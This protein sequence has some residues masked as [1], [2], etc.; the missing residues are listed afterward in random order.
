MAHDDR[1]LHVRLE[2]P[3]TRLTLDRPA[4]LN[5]LDDG[6]RL[7]LR[8]VLTELEDR[9][10]IRV[11]LLD[12]AGRAFSA[13]ADLRATAYPPI[14]GDWST[15]RHRAGTWQRLLD[16][17]ERVPQATVA[18]LHGHVVGG[19]A[20]LA[21]AFDIRVASADTRLRIPELAIGIPLTWAG[22]PRLIRE[23]GLPLT[24]DWVMSGRV[25]L[26]EELSRSGFAQR[27]AAPEDLDDAVEA[28]IGELLAMPPAALAMTRSM[29]AA[30][31]RTT[32]GM[33]AA[34]GDADHQQWAFT[35]H[36][37]HDAVRAYV[38]GLRG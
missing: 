35:E 14:E 29:T 37:Y 2:A 1:G 6:I 36:E 4:S 22:L 5:S 23:V 3:L 9:P 26:A 21:A 17:L 20:L 15:R 31:G 33:A 32:P 18:R 25:V 11:V 7:A 30:L 24:R 13:G 38:D 28:C 34:W 12:G 10:D 16:Q 27:V 8:E 19:A